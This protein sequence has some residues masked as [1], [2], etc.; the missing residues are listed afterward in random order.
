VNEAVQVVYP[1]FPRSQM[2]KFSLSNLPRVNLLQ[3]ALNEPAHYQKTTPTKPIAPKMI[4]VNQLLLKELNLK[5]DESLLAILSGAEH[6]ENTWS[7]RYGGHQFKQWAGQLGDGRTHSLAQYSINSKIHEIQ[8]KGS[9]LTPYSRFGDGLAV[10]RSSI[11]EYLC[12]EYMYALNV[13]TSRSLALCLTGDMVH[14]EELELGAI[15]A[16]ELDT[17]IRFGSFEILFAKDQFSE[18]K[19]LA[20]YVID[21]FVGIKGGFHGDEGKTGVNNLDKTK[22]S[23]GINNGDSNGPKGDQKYYDF[24]QIVVQKTAEM[25]AGWQ[26]VGFCH[27][28]MNT[29]NFSIIGKTIDYGPF[30]F[31]DKYDPYYICNHSDDMGIYSFMKQPQV[32]LWNLIRLANSLTSLFENFQ[33]DKMSEIIGSFNLVLQNKYFGLMGEKLGLVFDKEYVEMIQ[34]LL[35]LLEKLEFDYH[36]FFRMLSTKNVIENEHI[37]EKEC[38]ECSYLDRFNEDMVAELQDWY[39]EYRKLLIHKGVKESDRKALML[40]VNPKFVL[41]NSVLE[42]VIEKCTKGDME[43]VDKYLKVLQ[44]PF[45][46]GTEEEEKLFGG[47]VPKAKLGMKC[48]CSS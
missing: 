43:I 39:K 46:D 41:R 24:V 33:V 14:R 7:L 30:Q 23:K 10:L 20:D 19:Q 11:R 22:G 25:I 2:S 27:G 18:L 29:D 13:P 21:N 26:S 48:S 35:I 28:V 4:S 1:L 37:F 32:A 9:G 36:L 38:L 5:Q 15:C 16:R 3:A 31:L 34:N 45:K 6:V 42:N 17:W 40:S 12:S 44:N 47:I 8:L